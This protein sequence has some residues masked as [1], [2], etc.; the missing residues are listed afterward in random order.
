MGYIIH[1]T[2]HFSIGA[3]VTYALLNK[4]YNSI[5]K[6]SLVLLI[7][8]IAGITPDIT[9]FFGDLYGHSL[10][11]VPFLGLVIMLITRKLLLEISVVKLWFVLSFSVLSHIF[12]DFI[13]NGVALLYPLI[14]KE[15]A[16]HIIR[17]DLF[18]YILLIAL[19][20][21]I[22]YSKGKLVIL[23]SLL[24]VALYLG[25]LT[26]S[27]IQL[28]QTLKSEYKE[29]DI[30]LLLVYPRWDYRWEFIIRTNKL[31]ISGSSPIFGT[32]IQIE[33]EYEWND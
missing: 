10:L 4:Y 26:Y 12:I 32:D 28:Q 1:E 3:C 22:F 29:D 15:Y 30:T 31:S 5:E 20:I 23:S 27:K 18:L 16:F 9:K 2:L 24:I 7:G 25:V 8:G 21:A 14:T 33:R 13:G 19:I 11:L 17:D 6:V